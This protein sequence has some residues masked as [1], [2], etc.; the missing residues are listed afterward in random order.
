MRVIISSTG[1]D[2]K[3]EVDSRF[4][5]CPYYLVVDIEANQIKNIEAMENKVAMQGHG[6]GFAAAQYVGNLEPDCVITGNIGPNASNALQQL[7][8]KVYTASGIIK[9]VISKL[10]DGKLAKISQTVPG[11]FG[12]NEQL[13]EKKTDGKLERG[14]KK[15]AISTDNG[16]V[17]L[18]F[19]RCSQFTIVDIDNGRIVKKDV[20]KNPGHQTGYLPKFFSDMGV[21]YMIAGSAG[22]LAKDYF[23]EYKIKL[24]LG[25]QG[26]VDKIIKDF[27]EDKLES[28]DSIVRPGEGKGKGI[29]KTDD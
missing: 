19:G 10:L 26:K 29:E 20:I 5:R 14:F 23:K 22:P 8:I 7:G 28:G 2:L 17:A 4:G 13:S 16:N 11:H 12:T 3:S 1:K 6:A 21:D 18:H 24:I 9:D 15:L 25:V 27:I